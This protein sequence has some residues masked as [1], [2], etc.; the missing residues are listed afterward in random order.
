MQR[1]DAPPPYSQISTSAP[2]DTRSAIPTVFYSPSLP[3]SPS[4]TCAPRVLSNTTL[5]LPVTR[6]ENTLL[7]SITARAAA[8]R[9]E[10]PHL[11]L[12]R[13]RCSSARW[14]PHKT[15]KDM[16]IPSSNR[17]I[18]KHQPNR[19]NPPP[20]LHSC[21]PPE[22]HTLTPT[23]HGNRR[24][25]SGE[26]Q[27]H[28]Y[29]PARNNAYPHLQRPDQRAHSGNRSLGKGNSTRLRTLRLFFPAC[30]RRRYQT[31]ILML[32]LSNR[33]IYNNRSLSSPAHKVVLC[34]R[35]RCTSKTPRCCVPSCSNTSRSIP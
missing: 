7:T 1:E 31:G 18:T 3:R 33:L 26:Q 30:R 13:R 2:N 12:Y 35:R 25:S 28:S 5:P 8:Y 27:R 24:S 21:E 15:S 11:R 10:A 6:S 29:S 20:I 16:S 34:L 14:V 22:I 4:M 32:S 19:N 17:L 23:G 9:R